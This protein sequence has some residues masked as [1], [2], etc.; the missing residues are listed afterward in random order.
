[1]NKLTEGKIPANTVCPFKSQ[2]PSAT[3]KTCGHT[4]EAHNVPYSCGFARLFNIFNRT[5]TEIKNVPKK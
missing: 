5:L 2:C 4:G 3:D 1:M